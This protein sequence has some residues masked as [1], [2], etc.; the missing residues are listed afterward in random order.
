MN[1]YGSAVRDGIPY[2]VHF[3]VGDGDA[4][5]GP[6]DETVGGTEPTEAVADAVDHDVA[7]GVDAVRVGGCGL[8]WCW[9]TDAEGA[10]EGAVRVAADDAIG[11]FGDSVVS[12]VVLRAKS[13]SSESD[14]VLLD[15]LAL[16]EQG[17]GV[18]VLDDENGVGGGEWRGCAKPRDSNKGEDC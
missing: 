11:A 17:E 4:A 13:A 14:A 9:V 12:G 6:V 16:V 7:A 5:F 2:F 18:C 1:F 10:V 3:G 8:L 15:R